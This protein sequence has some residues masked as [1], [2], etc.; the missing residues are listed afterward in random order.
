MRELRLKTDALAWRHVDGEVIAVDLQS[1]TYLSAV[2]SGA[3]LW[4]AL[5]VGAT[6]DILVDLLT[7]EFG[8]ER[9]RAAVDVDAFVADLAD[10]KLLDEAAA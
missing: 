2:G 10:R 9:D 6:R 7:D 8:I 4:Q 5:A 3:L 1:S